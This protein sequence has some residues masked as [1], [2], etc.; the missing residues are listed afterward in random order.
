MNESTQDSGE[1]QA[2]T[3]KDLPKPS[4]T[5]IRPNKKYKWTPKGLEEINED[6]E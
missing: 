2:A 4:R 5:I 1:N 3:P 6:K